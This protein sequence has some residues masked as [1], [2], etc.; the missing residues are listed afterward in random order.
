MAILGSG[1]QDGLL[2]KPVTYQWAMDLYDQAVANTWFPN[3]I[4]LGEDLADFKKMT[5]DEKHALLHL[6]SYFNPNEL[7]VNK[8]LA[9]GVYPYINA[10]EGHLYLAKQMWEE[11]NHCMT[12]EYILETFPIDRDK[13]YSAHVDVPSMAA[14]EEFESKFIKR[15]T[16]DTLDISTTEGKKDFIRNLIAY[17][18]ILEGIW[19]YSG[20]MVALSFRQRNL[21]RNFGSLMDW[22][23][24]DESLHLQ[25]GIN[26]I[27]T[28][29]EENEDLQDEEFA[30]EIRGM[31]LHAVEMEEAYNRDMF[32]RGILG[33]NADY[34][35]QYVKY[36]TD[37]RLEELGFEPEFNVANPAKWMAAANDTLQL[38]NFFEQQNTSYEVN[39]QATK[40]S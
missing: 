21:L 11:A 3:E 5:E 25:F 23:I 22:I 30:E 7:L 10:P 26:L 38:V 24:R 9:F 29:L 17:N 4:Q 36:L 14:K 37:R 19:F 40:T 8:A 6:I 33:L 34:V 28:V 27:L 15:M 35:N 18:I 1:V 12:F 31:I 32:P 13:A 20:F 39:A 2:L 16:E